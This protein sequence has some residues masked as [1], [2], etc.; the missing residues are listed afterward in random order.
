MH[1]FLLLFFVTIVRLTVL[2]NY[3][4]INFCTGPWSSCLGGLHA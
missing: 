1:R 2:Q 4:M 3:F